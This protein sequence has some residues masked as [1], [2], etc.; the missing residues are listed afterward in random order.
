M[1][2]KNK[3]QWTW[4]KII[5]FV[6][7]LIILL[8][9]FARPE[10]SSENI[11][12]SLSEMIKAPEKILLSPETIQNQNKPISFEIGIKKDGSY[13][14]GKIQSIDEVVSKAKAWQKT[15]RE[16]ILL[17]LDNS[18]SLNRVD[19]VRE[20]LRKASLY[21]V[22]QR[23]VNSDEIIYPAGD[24]SKLAQL[25]VG[26][27]HDWMSNQL[28]NY[29]KDIPDDWEYTILY[30]FIIDKNGKVRDARIIEGC[31][32]PKVNEVYEKILTQIPDWNPAIK[33]NNVVSVLYTSMDGRKAVQ[34]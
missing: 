9:A 15:G 29:L 11:S 17:V 13:I 24:V 6:P 18:I 23:T 7:A 2:K 1:H 8:Q 25:K 3:K 16:D 10:I 22:N 21:H 32:Y 20:A 31:D 5:V 30:G 27:W 12:K 33:G 34:K 19:E 4:V 28:N 26:K 14:D